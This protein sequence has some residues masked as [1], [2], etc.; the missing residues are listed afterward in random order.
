MTIG[1]EDGHKKTVVADE[2]DADKKSSNDRG[3]DQ[4]ATANDQQKQQR[5]RGEGDDLPL[6]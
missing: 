1:T 3:D 4:D 5:R 2:V 6:C